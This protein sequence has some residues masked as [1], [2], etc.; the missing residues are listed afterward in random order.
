MRAPALLESLNRDMQSTVR[1]DDLAEGRGDVAEVWSALGAIM[2][3]CPDLAL[4]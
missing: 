1:G 4:A 3:A 2:V